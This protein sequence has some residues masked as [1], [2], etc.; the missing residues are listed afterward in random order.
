[1]L[2][3]VD[4]EVRAQPDGVDIEET[5]RTF[6]ENARLKASAVAAI[7]GQWTLADDSGL[8]VDAL[9]GAPGVYSARYAKDDPGRV[10]RLLAEL[11]GHL[12]RSAAFIS[13]VALADPAGRIVL[14]AEGECR[15]E[16]LQQSRGPLAS[17]YEG[18]FWIRAA[19]CTY[20]ELSTGQKLK[21]GSRGKAVRS[22]ADDVKAV[23]NLQPRPGHRADSSV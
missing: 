4:I 7:T 21:F 8:A 22:I 17:G 18:V 6:A 23:L 2:E 12:Y 14:E 13:A 3:V 20:G 16:I 5:G 11:R 9:H 10:A 1:M 19:G 15:G